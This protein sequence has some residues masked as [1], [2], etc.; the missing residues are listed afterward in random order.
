MLVL[1]RA[2]VAAVLDLDALRDAVAA[3]LRELSIGSPSIPPRIAAETPAGGLLATMP[4]SLPEL[5][6]LGAKLVT[7]FPDNIDAPTHQ[8]IVVLCDPA[9]GTPIALVDGTLVTAARTAAASAVATQYL[10]RADSS[11][12]TIVGTG[13]QARAHARAIP[14]VCPHLRA[15][16]V[17][18]RDAD[19]AGALAREL[20]DL[21]GDVEI[22]A[23]TDLP[24]ALADADIVCA[25]THSPDPV[26]RREWIRPGVHVSS[27]GFNTAGREVDAETVRDSRVVVESRSSALAPA[28]ANELLWAIRDGVIT[29]DHIDAEVGELVAGI[30]PGRERAEEITLYKSVGVAAEDLAAA[31]LVVAAARE[32]G[33]GTRIDL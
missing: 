3:G 26:V 29:G 10:A 32:R 13:V 24:R 18:G 27:V 17:A 19:R 12:L 23:T 33:I 30:R 25:T 28:G 14:R 15:I 6:A 4:G 31:L 7:V 8:A 1:S 5:G 16:R 9:S 20:H 2:D 11:V 22:T 21:D